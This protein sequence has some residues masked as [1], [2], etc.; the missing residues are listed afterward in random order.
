MHLMCF[1]P[2]GC[3]SVTGSR[4]TLRHGGK[5]RGAPSEQT[6]VQEGIGGR[7]HCP[8][9]TWSHG[10]PRP[11]PF[12]SRLGLPVSPGSDL[13]STRSFVSVSARARLKECFEVN[14]ELVYTEG[15]IRTQNCRSETPPRRPS[16]LC[17]G[18]SGAQRR[19]CLLEVTQ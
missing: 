3:I 18:A 5:E 16:Q 13:F 1:H 15:A 4:S 7:Q 6:G 2:W 8:R 17:Q 14:L 10:A 19:Q 12:Q 9:S 11:T